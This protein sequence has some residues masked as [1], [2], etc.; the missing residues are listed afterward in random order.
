M[1]RGVIGSR[2]GRRMGG[3]WGEDQD[4]ELDGSVVLFSSLELEQLR[5]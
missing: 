5:I 2:S 3:K 1:R 4:E